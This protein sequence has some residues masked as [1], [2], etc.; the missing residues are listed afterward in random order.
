L[1]VAAVLALILLVIL[2]LS[3]YLAVRRH[4]DREDRRTSCFMVPGMYVDG[5]WIEGHQQCP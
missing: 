3:I 4:E 5:S 2:P 1:I